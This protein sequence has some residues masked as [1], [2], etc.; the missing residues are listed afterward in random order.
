MSQDR[1]TQMFKI[2]VA[3]MLLPTMA[4]AST[5]ALQ[6]FLTNVTAYEAGFQQRT[7]DEHGEV[8]SVSAGTMAVQRGDDEVGRFRWQ[9]SEPW[10]QL[11]IG[12]GN[13][14]WQYDADLEQVT[15]R[16]M[17]ESLE[18]TPAELLSGKLSLNDWLLSETDEWVVLKPK[19]NDLPFQSIALRFEGEALGG[20][21]LIDQF[22]QTTHV[23]FDQINTTPQFA[24]DTFHFTP[25]QGAEIVGDV[26]EAESHDQERQ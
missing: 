8:Q 20:M 24:A 11:I 23:V 17:Q 1:V 5:A 14:L 25:P 6:N 13:K 9:Y 21:K 15:V 12:D 26:G 19:D 7:L 2:I 18:G 16:P 3:L 10:E 4:T 22:D